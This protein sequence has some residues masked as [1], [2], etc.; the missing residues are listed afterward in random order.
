MTLR[1]RV[2]QILE[3]YADGRKITAAL[4]ALGRAGGRPPQA[5]AAARRG[6]GQPRSSHRP[7]VQ[8]A[9]G[10]AKGCSRGRPQDRARAVA[11][12]ADAAAAVS[13]NPRRRAQ[14]QG[15]V[16]RRTSPNG[17][18]RPGGCARRWAST[19]RS[20]P[21]SSATSPRVH[22]RRVAG[23][24][25]RRGA[26]GDLRPQDRRGRRGRDDHRPEVPAR[27]ARLLGQVS[28]EQQAVFQ[29]MS[30]VGDQLAGAEGPARGVPDRGRRAWT[31][32]STRPSGTSGRTSRP[33]AAWP[34]AR[35]P[36]PRNR[37]RRSRRYERKPARLAAD[38]PGA[39]PHP[40]GVR[41]RPQPGRGG[42]ANLPAAL[43]RVRAGAAGGRPRRGVPGRPRGGSAGGQPALPECRDRAG[44]GAGRK[45]P[46]GG[47]MGPVARDGRGGR[48]RPG[49]LRAAGQGGH[50]PGSPGRIRD[51]GGRAD[52]AQGPRLLLD[53]SDARHG[54]CRVPG[55]RGRSALPL[56]ELRAGH[57]D[58]GRR[59]PAGP[60]GPGDRGSASVHAAD[61]DRGE[62]PPDV[63]SHGRPVFSVGN[64][65]AGAARGPAAC[66]RQDGQAGTAAG[67][68]SSET[69][70]G[71]W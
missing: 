64:I 21:S 30:G 18:A 33:S 23:T 34:G 1:D 44:P 55:G 22:G 14:G 63:A 59:H 65:S 8:N 46:L 60:P 37:G 24:S 5:R 12:G 15:S 2:E 36:R 7:D 35:S 61:D 39:R 40:R 58:R 71:G 66:R 17:C 42:R 53:G 62:P 16:R 4:T 29:L 3:R 49:P 11:G 51:P 25:P 54:E 43:L 28:Q 50:S 19:R 26:A 45:L 9:R 32:S 57:P 10:A 13:A 41:D 68:W 70:E 48:G 67:S 56:A 47:R 69:A 6:G 20:R 52:H 31:S 27:A 38:S